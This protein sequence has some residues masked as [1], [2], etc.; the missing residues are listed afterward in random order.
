MLKTKDLSK[1]STLTLIVFLSNLLFLDN[2]NY[3]ELT[4][5]R[6]DLIRFVNF[7]L[8]DI[9]IVYMIIPL[10]ISGIYT[11]VATMKI[12]RNN[13]YILFISYLT[14]VSIV[15]TILRVVGYS[16]ALL[17]IN[18]L[19]VPI[20]SYFVL[21]TQSKLFRLILLVSLLS[22]TVFIGIQTFQQVSEENKVIDKSYGTTQAEIDLNNEIYFIKS[23]G[24]KIDDFNNFVSQKT[25][26]F[27][28]GKKYV[29]DIFNI[30]CV[31]Y[32]YRNSGPAVKQ[33][34]VGYVSIKNDLIYYL[35]GSGETFYLNSEDVLNNN[36]NFINIKNN[37]KDINKNEEIYEP[38]WESTKDLMI[39][40]NKIYISFVNEV[41]DNCVASEIMVGELNTQYIEFEYFFEHEECVVRTN[42]DYEP[43]NAHLAGGKMLFDQKTETIIFSRG[44]FRNYD[45]AQDPNSSLGKIIQ[46]NL[47]GKSYNTIALGTRNPQGLT[48]TKDGKFILETEHGP[49]GGDE[50]NLLDINKNNV[51][52]GWPLSS[53][54]DHWRMDYYEVFSELAP[55][56]KS[57]SDYGFTEPVYWFR[58]ITGGHGISDIDINYFKNSNSYFVATLNGRRLYDIDFDESNNTV[59]QIEA[60]PIGERIRDIEYIEDKNIYLLVLEDTPAFGILKKK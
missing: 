30:C 43:F 23:D 25:S 45:R 15:F 3:L 9:A 36:L 40:E 41:R 34:S 29:L 57:H 33:K 56:N 42:S 21:N 4:N 59:L 22:G 13:F 49:N 32:N 53:Y 31:K 28:I 20:I 39:I 54:G 26:S 58:Q 19:I 12:V 27:D 52:Y 35:T 2:S 7:D 44:D 11:F 38:G 51:N 6:Y 46:I 18:I 10:L 55:L 5:L 47:D 1:I 14:V 50:I 8:E 24:D 48:H 16:R 60:F 37:F 17:I